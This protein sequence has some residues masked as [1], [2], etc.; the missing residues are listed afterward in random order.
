MKKTKSKFA[1][2]VIFVCFS[3]LIFICV[4]QLSTLKMP[5][6]KMVTNLCKIH[7]PNAK[8]NLKPANFCL[9]AQANNFDLQNFS[10]QTEI[11]K[12]KIVIPCENESIEFFYNAK[13]FE[14]KLK[15]NIKNSNIFSINQ[16]LN[17]FNRF[18]DRQTRQ[19][20]LLTMLNASIDVDVAL[21][22]LYPNLNLVINRMEK[23]IE[24]S[25]QNATLTTAPNSEKVFFIKK[26]AEGLKLDKTKLYKQIAINYL[27]NKPMQFNLPTISI[28]PQIFACEFEKYT[29]LRAD[30]STNIAS[31]SADRKHNIK[32]ALNSLNMCEIA[33]DQIFSFNKTVGRRT[34][35]NGYRP[36]KIIVNNEF[37]DGLGGGVCQVSTTLYNSALLAGLQIVE[38]NKHSKQVGYV[39]YGFDA[40]VNF[41]S[42]DLKFKN[43]TGTKIIIVT[44]FTPNKIRIRI[45][46][47][48]LGNI[49]FKLAS[50]II[51]TTLPNEEII[52]DNKQEYTDKVL[53]DDQSFL[54]KKGSVGM[55]IKSYRQKYVS[56]ELVSTE[57][58]RFDKFKAQNAVRVYGTKKRAE[59]GALND[60]I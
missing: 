41:G 43:N 18:K 30:F 15:P 54:L 9:P 27:S 57:L 19:Q 17:K 36:A 2:C 16:Q 31:S 12:Q 25:A 38:A 6:N 21:N 49:K 42:S 59:Q 53:Y 34:M 24:R 56:G 14:Y 35:D 50:E 26:E 5:I 40:M 52:K 58:I 44:N 39:K 8:I 47:E 33:P 32:N 4:C 1:L 13:T 55:E 7:T 60:V 48:S 20:L 3:I 10:Q 22:Y 11:E 28:K 51:S 46:G 29:N 37:V 45:F 23:N